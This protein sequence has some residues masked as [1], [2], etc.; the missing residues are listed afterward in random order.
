MP[1][2][3]FE[4]LMLPDGFAANVR[5]DLDSTGRITRVTPNAENP[6][7]EDSPAET[8][9]VTGFRGLGLPGMTNL[10][11]HA[12]Q[13][14]LAATAERPAPDRS[15]FWSWRTKMYE[16]ALRVTPGDLETIAEAL[17]IELLLGGYTAVCEFHYVHH[18]PDGSRYPA[19]NELA[20]RILAGAI[21]AGLPVTM[22]PTLYQ[23]GGFATP[24][25]ARQRRFVRSTEEHLNAIAALTKAHADSPNVTVGLSI[26]SLRAVS[27]EALDQ[28][29]RG[30]KAIA[31]GGPIHIHIAEQAAEIDACLAHTGQRPIAWLLD[32]ASVDSRYCLVHATHADLDEIRRVAQ[33]GAVVGICPTTEA[34]LGDGILDAKAYLDAGAVIGIGSDQHVATEAAAEIRALEYS[35]RLARHSRAVLSGPDQSAA[36]R[37]WRAAAHGGA[38][39]SGRT[40]GELAVGRPAD[41]TVIDTHSARVAGL[42]DAEV[43]DA[44]VFAPGTTHVTD[45]IVAGQTVIRDRSHPRQAE[46]F[47]RLAAVLA[48]L[49]SPAA[50]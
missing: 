11:S 6:N 9:D 36:E 21:R 40:G 14:A 43:L 23:Q 28:V 2:L 29:L 17:A 38:Q 13:F 10:H 32:S 22:L 12:F 50:R 44:L 27:A 33:C 34:D 20:D 37:T 39:A 8:A 46:V 7:A 18:Q 1:A 42:I 41:I 3:H 48:R 25:T 19:A 5:L 45:V 31:P 24:A 15:D 35:Q 47:E 49:R 30:F 16:L 26:H 4:R